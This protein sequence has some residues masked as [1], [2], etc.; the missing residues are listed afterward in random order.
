MPAIPVLK[1]KIGSYLSYPL[2]FSEIGAFLTPGIERVDVA[3][4]FW[5]Y[6]APRQNEARKV[7]D[8][9]SMEYRTDWTGRGEATIRFT[10]S[11][12]PR[13]LRPAIRELLIPDVM[14]KV[15]EWF[16]ALPGVN[17]EAPDEISRW[18]IVKFDTAGQSLVTEVSTGSG[19]RVG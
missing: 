19:T 4:W 17:G 14:A 12:V 16:H 3:A 5:A 11:P 18:I 6:K 15:R 10:A 1:D 2:K 13:A 8:V 9:V 7:Y